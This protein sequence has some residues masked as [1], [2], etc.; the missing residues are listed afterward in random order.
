[1]S[2]I[3]QSAAGVYFNVLVQTGADRNGITGLWDNAIRLSLTA[4]PVAGE[5]NQA[6]RKYFAKLF[7]V[8]LAQVEIV[9]G[10]T[11]HV[12]TIKVAG[13]H[14]EEATDLLACL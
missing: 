7:N 3:K 11:E 5:E 6:C 12:K 4:P 1:M 14:S 8:P 13:V 10:R 2:V 9:A